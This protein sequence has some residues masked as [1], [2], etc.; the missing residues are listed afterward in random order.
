MTETTNVETM[1][2]QGGVSGCLDMIDQTKL[3]TEM[4]RIEC[5]DVE[6]VWEAIKM[7]RVRG[8]PAIGI[9]AAYG[10]VL[11]L[12]SAE[13]QPTGEA[14]SVAA[15]KEVFSDPLLSGELPGD[16]ELL[17]ISD[18]APNAAIGIVK[19]YRAYREQQDRL[20]DLS[21]L[22]GQSGQASQPGSKQL[23][24]DVVRNLFE[25][26]PWSARKRL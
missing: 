7:L 13:E 15:L 1:I 16:T 3:P 8:A 14:G 26:M 25:S 17:E 24:V 5:E 21:Q 2:W 12:Q 4:V 19:L 20:S 18:G 23:P 9:A 22:M 10:V 11:G 6:T